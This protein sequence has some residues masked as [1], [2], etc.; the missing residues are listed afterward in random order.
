MAAQPYLDRLAALAP[1]R[2]TTASALIEGVLAEDA[3]LRLQG[4][5]APT[6]PPLAYEPRAALR[7]S[8]RHTEAL[9]GVSAVHGRQPPRIDRP[10][11][12]NAQ[13]L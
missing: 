4:A 6:R 10:P 8:V 12:Q 13:P 7:A 5:P 9:S 1:S 11:A 3:C 2:R